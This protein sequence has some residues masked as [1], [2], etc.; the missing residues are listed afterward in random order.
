MAKY[1]KVKSTKAIQYQNGGTE[2]RAMI[3]YETEIEA[4]SAIREINR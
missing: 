4:Q 1:G 3:F 2:N